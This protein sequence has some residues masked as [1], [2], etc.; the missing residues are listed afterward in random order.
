MNDSASKNGDEQFDNRVRKN[1][2]SSR[3]RLPYPIA[4]SKDDELTLDRLRG[5]HSVDKRLH[6]KLDRFY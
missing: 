1:L 6:N 4:G 3:P 2:S 5:T